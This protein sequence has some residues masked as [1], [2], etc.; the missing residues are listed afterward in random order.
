[1]GGRLGLASRMSC[2][3]WIV[4]NPTSPRVGTATRILLGL[5]T[6]SPPRALPRLSK[7]DETVEPPA[8]R[9]EF[10]V[11]LSDGE[12][13]EPLLPWNP[14]LARLPDHASSSTPPTRPR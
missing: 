8:D 10:F 11:Q 4:L 1:M 14:P 13:L 9:R 3:R 2:K 7:R 12:A 6:D 5:L